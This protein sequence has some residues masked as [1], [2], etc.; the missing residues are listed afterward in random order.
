MEH[1]Q[2]ARAEGWRV[3]AA[4]FRRAI[5]GGPPQNIRLFQPAIG[6]V[7]FKVRKRLLGARLVQ[8]P[9]KTGETDGVW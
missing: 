2:R 1:I 7:T 8:I 9:A 4:Q 3:G 5:Q 6:K